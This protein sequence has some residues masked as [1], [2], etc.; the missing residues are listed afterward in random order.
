M[1]SSIKAGLALEN[2][3]VLHLVPKENKRRLTFQA[4]ERRAIKL[5]SKVKHFFKATPTPIMPHLPIVP[6]PGSSSTFKPP[7]QFTYTLFIPVLYTPTSLVT[8]IP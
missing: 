2:L 5:T 3:R 6:L 1:Y 7:H 4:A 8:I